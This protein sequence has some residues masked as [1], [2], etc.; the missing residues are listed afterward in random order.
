MAWLLPTFLNCSQ[1]SSRGGWPYV[2]RYWLGWDVR[3]EWTDEYDGIK[4]TVVFVGVVDTIDQAIP[5]DPS[6]P[7]APAFM[8]GTGTATG[9]RAGWKGCNPGIPDVPGGGGT[10]TFGATIIGDRIH[11]GAFTDIDNPLFGV[12]TGVFDVPIEGGTVTIPRP[13]PVGSLCPHTSYGTITVTPAPDQG[14]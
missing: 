4:D 5:Q 3:I 2:R 14:P 6:Q 9:R 12:T 7:E 8:T 10:A 1:E 11:V 13:D